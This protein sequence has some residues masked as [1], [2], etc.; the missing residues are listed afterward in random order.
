[1]K[2]LHTADWQM[3]MKAAHVGAA[4]ERV[5]GQRLEAAK[6]VV[7]VAHD[8]AVDFIIVAGD[9]FEDNA[10]S[11]T[12]VQKVGD[13]LASFRGPVYLIPGNHD[14]LAPGSV[15][16]HAVWNSHAN[17]HVIA[18]AQPLAIP[19]GTLFP[20]PLFEKY[21]TRD[22]TAWIDAKNDTGIAVGLAHGTVEG[23]PQV[24][25]DYPIPRNAATRSG[26]D[27]LGVGHWH[28]FGQIA[29]EPRIYYSGTHETTKF[30]ERDSGN[31]AIVEIAGRGATPKVT[32][33][34]TGTLAWQTLDGNEAKISA[35]GDLTRLR[36]RIEALPETQMS[37]VR[38]ELAGVLHPSEVG[39]IARI[40]ELLE[41]RFVYGR[42]DTAQLL[43]QPQDDAWLDDVPAGVMKAVAARLRDLSRAD[44]HGER[45]TEATPAVATQAL[46]D[47]YRIL[48]EVRA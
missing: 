36:E 7:S 18:E 48:H 21:S 31:V 25:P 17:L 44:F 20:C 47:L 12:L 19:G 11:R 38:V 15:W 45:P 16:Q 9:T 32:P 6:N 43:P 10:V 34:R 28:S 27:Y 14:P 8:E 29:G 39:E 5:R 33:R 13:I 22:P 24:E 46:L 26:L 40:S 4:G 23:I 30:G 3:G 37:L 41:S 35:E 2:F 42:L 1:M